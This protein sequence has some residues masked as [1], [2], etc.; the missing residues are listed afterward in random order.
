MRLRAPARIE[1]YVAAVILGGIAVLAVIAPQL[2][3]LVSDPDPRLAILVGAVLI[4]ELVPIRLGP[5]QGEV[6]PSTTFTFA[7]LLT[8]GAVPAA[9]AQGLGSVAADV[10]HRRRPK[11]V[12]FN[13]SQYLLA[14]MAAGLVHQLIAGGPH[15]E[16]I[17]T[18][19][20]VGVLAAGAVFFAFN[21]G[22]VAVA[23]SLSS[24]TRLKDSLAGDLIRQSATESVLI[25][26]APL[27]VVALESNLVLLPLIVLPLLA[28]QR[29][30]R[31]AQISE[32]LA[33]HDALTGLPNRSRFYQRIEQGIAAADA[34]T[35]IALLLIDLDRF[36]EINDTLGHHYGDEVL[37][38]VGLRLQ[39]RVALGTT[40]ARLGGD[41]FAILLPGQDADAALLFADGIRR[42]LGEPLDVGGVR[43]DIG[44]SVGVA[45]YPQDGRDVETLMQ[46]AD[47]AMYEAKSG[48]TGVQRYA[49]E[50]D[51]DNLIRLTLAGDLRRALDE[52]EIVTEFQPKIDLRGDRVCG[53]EALVRWRHRQRG[54]I[55]PE[56]FIGIAEQTG[57]IVP[58]TMHVLGDAVRACHE[59]RHHGVHLT[60]AV[61]LSA[62]VLLEPDL[63]ESIVGLCAAHDVPPDA[64]VL[65]ITESM[66]VTDPER[67][68][69]TLD[70]LAAAGITL[71]VDDFG[72]GY[73][74]LE[75][76]K[77]LPVRELKID[78][79]FVMGMRTDPRDTAIVRSA[80]HLGHS[81]GLRIV[82][83]G[84]D[85]APTHDA[86]AS[87]DCD[88]AQG[89]RYSPSLPAPQLLSWAT[90]YDERHT[91]RPLIGPPRFVAS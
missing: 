10:A 59:W 91:H 51:A 6:A 80:I 33:M 39:Q 48:R 54:E 70:R 37:K 18:M 44:G 32:H 35:R 86:L 27:A 72:T 87:L 71:S 19:Q 47:I 11:F 76:L 52:G 2:P 60:V 31:Q 29:A 1:L 85:S 88:Q 78:R 50:Q 15:S 25:G 53:A 83:E 24:G 5:G 63:P 57:F 66:V 7:I 65:E 34:D 22:A 67:V 89:F 68:L 90:D 64:L 58:I 26:L 3:A 36:K 81:L 4:G 40:V 16:D 42:S 45:T 77:L 69:P 21:T 13:L 55:A 8:F 61:N 49:R 82:A 28:V 30:A 74:S 56:L 79:G 84:V 43:L 73:S 14:V 20:L 46:R 41:E 9:V 23:I 38:Q 12:A 17:G 75:Y 62:R